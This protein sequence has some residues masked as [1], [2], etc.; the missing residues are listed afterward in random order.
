[1]IRVDAH[2]H[3]WRL[4]RGDYSWLT[5]AQGPLFR[6]FEPEHLVGA[7]ADCRVHATV[8]VQAAPTEAETRFLLAQAHAQPSVAGVVGWVDFEAGD[9]RERIRAAVKES[10]GKLKG[11]RPMI[12]DIGDTQWLGRPSLDAAF[13]A[14]IESNLTFDALI[15]PRH[16]SILLQRLRRHP[17]LRAVLDHAGKPEVAGGALEPWAAWIKELARTTSMHCKLSG[18]LSQAQMGAGVA[19]LDDY[20]AHVFSCFGSERVM[21]GSD[22]PLVTVRASYRQWLELALELVNR[23][24]PGSES[25]V[26][27]G[28][29]IRFYGLD[30]GSATDDASGGTAT[31]T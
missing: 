3:Y 2:Q 18:L 15:M 7:L 20:V 17:G 24:A 29:A 12:Q 19:E 27:G 26:F 6:D 22:W 30:L 16:L 21:W 1:V 31:G 14:M 8:L 11:L 5:P 9:A 13:E 28:N 25:A 23:H 4:A 10:A